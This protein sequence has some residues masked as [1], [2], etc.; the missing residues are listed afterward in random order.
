MNIK[1]IAYLF[2]V[3]VIIS[4]LAINAEAQEKIA[5]YSMSAL[6]KTEPLAM[7]IS[8]SDDNTLW[9]D[10]F[11]AYEPDARCGFTLDERTKSNFIS[12]AKQAKDLYTEW[13]KM[14]TEN[15]LGDVKQKM[16][17]IYFT[18]GYFTY[19]DELK[20]DNNV[21]IIFAFAN[22]KGDY[23]LIMNLDNMTARDNDEIAFSGG[24]IVFNS[25]DEID[26]FLNAI[27]QESI[28]NLRAS[29]P[30]GMLPN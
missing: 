9:I 28:S 18:G 2:L 7:D 3:Q 29:K 11:S 12:T 24:S 14:A 5:T 8:L 30:V 23:V 20:Q 6:G 13:K 16:H 26:S 25:E 22:F 4:V 10:M 19:F 27:S 21:R 15:N 1:T 17:F